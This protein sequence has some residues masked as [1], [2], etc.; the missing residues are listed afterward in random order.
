MMKNNK[1]Y[2]KKENIKKKYEKKY[3]KN[4]YQDKNNDTE[5]DYSNQIEGR[6]PVKEALKSGRTIEKILVAKGE[7]TG[8]I[9]EIIGIA[10][11]QKLVIQYVERNRLDEIAISHAHQGVIAITSA[12]SYVGVEDILEN[13]KQ[14][15]EDGFLIILDEVTDPH[16]LGSILRTADA[17]GVH[18]V[19]I[20][21]RRAVGLTP[22]VAKSSAGAIEYMPVAKVSNIAQTIDY[23]KKQGYWIA[24]AEMDAKE[25]YYK[26]NLK[27]PI[28]IVIGSEGKGIGR[29]IKEKCDF[30]LKIPMLGNV[31]SL[32]AAI[33]GAILMYEI[34]RQRMNI[35]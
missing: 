26:A 10:K 30:L 25:Y 33:A 24:G 9:K 6:N 22:I 35:D 8:S 2:V 17:C 20:P 5:S 21:K 15:E 29:L 14:K 16:N 4:S 34:R 31:S 28:A 32:N 12:H 3:E 7:L 27:G 18:G 23:L 11:D 19:I 13:A 1:K